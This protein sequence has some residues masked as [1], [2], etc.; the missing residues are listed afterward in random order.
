[1]SPRQ[2]LESLERMESLTLEL[3]TKVFTSVSGDRFQVSYNYFIVEYPQDGATIES[4]Y[5][6]TITKLAQ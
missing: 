4:L 6:A 5:E 3:R 1:M 2:K